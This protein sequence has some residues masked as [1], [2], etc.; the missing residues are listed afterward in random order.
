MKR[1]NPDRFNDIAQDC[2]YGVMIELRSRKG[3]D[4][5]WKSL[6]KNK[7]KIVLR[8]IVVNCEIA[9]EAGMFR[10]NSIK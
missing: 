6:R 1:I 3:F 8:E 9:I 4:N 5:F 10:L 7:R 2:A